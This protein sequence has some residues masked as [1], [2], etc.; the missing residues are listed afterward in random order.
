MDETDSY[1]SV[2]KS[3][4]SQIR[5]IANCMPIFQILMKPK[6][7]S[8][9]MNALRPLFPCC[10]CQW[11]ICT[12]TLALAVYAKT[13]ASLDLP[14]QVPACGCGFIIPDYK[15]S[16]AS[17]ILRRSTIEALGKVWFPD[18]KGH[19][20]RRDRFPRLFCGLFLGGLNNWLM[21]A[22]KIYY[23]FALLSFN[24]SQIL[25]PITQIVKYSRACEYVGLSRTIQLKVIL[26][27]SDSHFCLGLHIRFR[28]LWWMHVTFTF[29]WVI[30]HDLNSF[31]SKLK[32]CFSSCI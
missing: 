4:H 18:R 5:F 15:K 25:S 17:C 16:L 3:L 23:I 2:D 22:A 28:Q 20:E 9:S 26:S 12:A 8:I 30:V 7:I 11:A 13:N 27:K 29:V 19:F 31:H 21:G 14:A 24:N 10:L 1:D 6:W 32:E